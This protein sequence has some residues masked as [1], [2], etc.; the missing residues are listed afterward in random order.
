MTITI[1]TLVLGS[2]NNNTYLITDKESKIAAVIDPS[3]ASRELL[4]KIT[5]QGLHL[6][7]ILITHAH[8]DHIGGVKWLKE[9]FDYKIQVALHPSDLT[10][11]QS[12]GSAKEFGFDFN[13]GEEP[14]LIILNDQILKLGNTSIKVLHTPGHT[15]GHVTFLIEV[16]LAAFCGDLIFYHGIGRTDL[17][18]SNEHDLMRSIVEKIFKLDPKMNL[19][20]GH[21]PSTSVQEEMENNPFF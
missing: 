9:Q 1:S 11:W 13:A 6:E 3:I 8:F 14:D 18:I 19:Y 16:G 4:Q 17:K 15:P 5:D 2:I 7:Y 10:L 20:P 12:G 21:G